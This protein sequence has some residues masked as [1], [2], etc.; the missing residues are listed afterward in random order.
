MSSKSK[1]KIND[2]IKAIATNTSSTLV[3]KNKAVKKPIIEEEDIIID[4]SGFN[5][6]FDIG[7]KKGDVTYKKLQLHEQILHRPDTYIGSCKNIASTD[8]IYVKVSDRIKEK[9]ITYP[10]GLVR[11]FIEAVS[12]LGYC[13]K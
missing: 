6:S 11:L 5:T 3:K 2:A 13:L 9:N 4:E 7:K 10:E 12:N 1:A 8:P